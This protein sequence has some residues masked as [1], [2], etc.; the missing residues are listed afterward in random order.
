MPLR[1][2]RLALGVH[3]GKYGQAYLPQNEVWGVSIEMADDVTDA[4]SDDCLD[5]RILNSG[6]KTK[7][8]STVETGKALDVLIRVITPVDRWGTYSERFLLTIPLVRKAISWRRR[9]SC[10]PV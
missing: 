7:L 5:G 4:V 9:K 1:F 10:T 3:H 6:F 8:T 2:Y